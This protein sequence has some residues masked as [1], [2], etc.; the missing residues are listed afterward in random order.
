[1]HARTIN[2]K[3]N[4]AEDSEV[5]NLLLENERDSCHKVANSLA[6]LYCSA[7]WNIK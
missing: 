3:G 2:M 7:L 5:K 6:E 1:M 4:S